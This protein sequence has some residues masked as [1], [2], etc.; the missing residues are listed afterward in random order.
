MFA[1]L[2][3]SEILV[4]R[5]KGSPHTSVASVKT[6]APDVLPSPKI[7]DVFFLFRRLIK[8]QNSD[9]CHSSELDFGI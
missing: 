6:A 4:F 1:V 2:L 9:I 7:E 3:F 5:W 8:R